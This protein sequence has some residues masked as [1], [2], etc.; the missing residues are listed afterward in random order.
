MIGLIVVVF[1]LELKQKDDSKLTES[2][3]Q[4]NKQFKQIAITFKAGQKCSDKVIQSNF[5]LTMS[6]FV[7]FSFE[8]QDLDCD[9]IIL[10]VCNF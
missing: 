5:P 10:E 7:H 3:I 1:Q 4:L 8:P 6:G 2:D 9:E